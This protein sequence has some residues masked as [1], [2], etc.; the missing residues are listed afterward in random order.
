VTREH[1][2]IGQWIDKGGPVVE[3]IELNEV[4]IEIPVL[5]TFISE[6]L[7]RTGTQPGTRTLG[8][9]VD[10]LP[11][12][13]FQGE[14][15]SIIPQADAQS[16]TFPVKVRVSNRV[17]PD[18]QFVL[19]TGMFARVTL[20]VK[21][22]RNAVMVSKDALVLGQGSP[23]VW[24]VV[25]GPGGGQGEGDRVRPVRVDVSLDV[26]DGTIV[27]IVGPVGLDGSLPLQ[28]GDL[29]VTEGNER[30]NP[31]SIV[32]VTRRDPSS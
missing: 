4:E 10:A 5:E 17:G 26:S 9:E 30:V 3:L 13:S 18:G 12:E 16:R 29:V 22:I 6:L 20:P 32:S 31:S 11:G 23:V 24:V 15:V 1:T 28:P 8:I 27:Q 19:R 7:Q 14:I 25:P 2:Q 21:T